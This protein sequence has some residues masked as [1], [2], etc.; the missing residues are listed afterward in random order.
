MGYWIRG[1]TYITCTT[2]TYSCI[3][4]RSHFWLKLDRAASC[5]ASDS[6]FDSGMAFLFRN[7]DRYHG[8][9]RQWSASDSSWTSPFPSFRRSAFSSGQSSRLL[10]G[11]RAESY[12]QIVDVPTLQIQE[13]VSERVVEQIRR[14]GSAPDLRPAESVAEKLEGNRGLQERS[15][16]IADRARL[17]VA[18]NAPPCTRYSAHRL[19]ARGIEET[20]KKSSC[21]EL[22]C[23]TTPLVRDDSARSH[24]MSAQLGWNQ[25]SGGIF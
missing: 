16:P 17:I 24:L 4:V 9:S 20:K 5:F 15:L 8:F 3:P 11:A 2:G 12:D 22:E 21:V 10:T 18:K 19:L 6:V 25:P 23:G 14:S 7:R 1:T 13:R